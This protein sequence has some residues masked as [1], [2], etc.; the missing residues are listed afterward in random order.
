MSEAFASILRAERLVDICPPLSET[1][2]SALNRVGR[3]TH[4]LQ[5][6]H[7]WVFVM[8]VQKEPRSFYVDLV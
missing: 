2:R 4:G 1:G 6:A 8:Q 5:R 3:V 7:R